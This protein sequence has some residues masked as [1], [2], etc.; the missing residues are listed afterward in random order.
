MNGQWTRT[1]WSLRMVLVFGGLLP[2]A[3]GGP[4][5]PVGPDPAHKVGG[6]SV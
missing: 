4:L 3:G 2:P 6:G 1:G 5:V